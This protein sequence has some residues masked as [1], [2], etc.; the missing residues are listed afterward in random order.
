[1]GLVDVVLVVGM[2]GYN[3]MNAVE[4]MRRD[5]SKRHFAGYSVYRSIPHIVQGE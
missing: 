1:M 5:R 3:L 4:G 2:Y